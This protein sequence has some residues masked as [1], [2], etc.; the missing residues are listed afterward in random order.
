M[1]LDDLKEHQVQVALNEPK[2]FRTEI[3][4]AVEK[5]LLKQHHHYGEP[6]MYFKIVD[7]KEMK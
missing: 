6:K 2:P 4:A 7:F 3:Y 5:V 1:L